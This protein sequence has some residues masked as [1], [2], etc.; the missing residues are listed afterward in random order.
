M[1]AY[2]AMAVTYIHKLLCSQTDIFS[3]PPGVNIIVNLRA[4]I[5]VIAKQ[6]RLFSKQPT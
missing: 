4:H 1:A 5:M 2:N 3:L 6:S